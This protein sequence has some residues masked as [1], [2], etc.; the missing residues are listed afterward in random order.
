MSSKS[1]RR[2]KAEG[3]MRSANLL[4]FKE[5]KDGA[6]R[7]YSWTL[8]DTQGRGIARCFKALPDSDQIVTDA[9]ETLGKGLWNYHHI[10][11]DPDW[12]DRVIDKGIELGLIEEVF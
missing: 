9:I 10:V 1:R 3:R 7:L 2:A 5:R 8:V 11:E 4:Q 6:N 12:F